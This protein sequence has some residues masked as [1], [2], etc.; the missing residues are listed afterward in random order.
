MGVLEE[1]G[2]NPRECVRDSPKS[3]GAFMISHS[4]AT[5]ASEVRGPREASVEIGSS[6]NVLEL[7]GT[8]ARPSVALKLAPSRDPSAGLAGQRK[9]A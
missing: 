3:T 4:G 5:D 8:G 1:Q 7:G 9:P 6:P 2:A